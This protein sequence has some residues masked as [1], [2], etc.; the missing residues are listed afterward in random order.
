M[1]GNNPIPCPK[2][3]AEINFHFKQPIGYKKGRWSEFDCTM[4]AR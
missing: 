1:K 4:A 3:I 2:C